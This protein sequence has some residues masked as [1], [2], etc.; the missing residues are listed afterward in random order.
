VGVSNSGG[1]IA[2]SDR[3]SLSAQY[4]R[5]LKQ[6]LTNQPKFKNPP[7]N[8]S[9][10]YHKQ[11]KPDTS[12]LRS[13]RQR[14]RSPK[15]SPP[16][17]SSAKPLS[18]NNYRPTPFSTPKPRGFAPPPPNPKMSPPPS[19]MPPP[20]PGAGAKAAAQGLGNV[21]SKLPGWGKP[22]AAAL[23]LLPPTID[24]YYK[25]FPPPSKPET[26]GM[27]PGNGGSIINGVPPWSGGMSPGIKY[28][29]QVFTQYGS[30][31]PTTIAAATVNNITGSLQSIDFFWQDAGSGRSTARLYVTGTG[32]SGQFIGV[33]LYT[34]QYI[35]SNQITI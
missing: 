10:K 9:Y 2:S 11:Q 18:S 3:T 23:L 5:G 24:L 25:L 33:T 22:V 28:K 4:N 20:S 19:P 1:S 32:S 12:N 6:G 27:Y 31:S 21:A 34:T 14:I 13:P 30:P 35:Y 7:K 26:S 29:I 16:P 8:N 15:T 17:P